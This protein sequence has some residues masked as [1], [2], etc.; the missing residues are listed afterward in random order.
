MRASSTAAAAA[1]SPRSIRVPA[2]GG[3][4]LWPWGR[5]VEGQGQTAEKRPP[6][7]HSHAPYDMFTI[8]AAA[9]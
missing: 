6:P 5:L 3:I 8:G 2:G 7:K 9:T 4:E 1:A